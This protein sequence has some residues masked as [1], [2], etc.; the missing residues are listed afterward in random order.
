[1]KK[2]TI[3]LLLIFGFNLA[4]AQTGVQID[5][6][7]LKKKVEKSNADI[8]NPKKN[9]KEGTWMD[10]A[11]LMMDIFDSQMLKTRIGMGLQ[12]FMII[13]GQPKNRV[14]EEVE[15][16]VV[17]KLI[18]DRA[19]FYFV[20]SML[21]K[22][23]VLNPVVEKP[24]DIAQESLKKATEIDVA[25]KKSKK[26]KELYNQLKGLYISE[27]SN[28][29][30]FKNYTGAFNCFN[31]VII[32]GQLPLMNQ[33]DTAIYYYSALSAQFAGKNQ[34]AIEQY[35]KAI[36]LGFTSEGNAYSNID[37]AYRALGDNESG[38]KYLEE[39]FTKF[40][41]NQSLLIALINYY[42]NKNEDPSKV[43]TYIDKAIADDP[44]NASLYHAKGT[45]YDKLKEFEQAIE[46]YKKAIEVNPK[47]FD[48]YFNIGVIYYNAA[49][50]CL[51]DANKVP[52]KE[53]EKYDAL[54]AKANEEFKKALPYMEKANELTPNDKY[55]LESLKNIYFRYRR[56]NDEMQKKYD[57]VIENLKNL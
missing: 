37:Q 14:T 42:L 31:S 13:A 27:G 26:I 3:I 11:E 54:I 44:T 46:A 8:E 49:I 55:T 35:K 56:D 25:G 22:Y 23:E 38:L 36:E 47:Y 41:K 24:L 21:E 4:N 43:I 5:F 20:N 28:F 7:Q 40:P 53:L 17:E 32:I 52:A 29:Y 2:L 19:V 50:K 45:I 9:I 15:G 6:D 33:K 57:A 34:E 39:G 10:R 16:T 51:E 1:M 30:A 18:M 48:P 12:E